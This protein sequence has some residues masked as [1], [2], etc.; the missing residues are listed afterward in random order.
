MRG[1]YLVLVLSTTEENITFDFE[2]VSLVNLSISTPLTKYL[3][4]IMGDSLRVNKKRPGLWS[5]WAQVQLL[6]CIAGSKYVALD[7]PLKLFEPRTS[8]QKNNAY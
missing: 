7:W 2:L 5:Q 4:F 3:K 8:L 1:V 6:G